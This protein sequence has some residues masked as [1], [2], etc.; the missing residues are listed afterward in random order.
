M[1]SKI[2]DA[3]GAVIQLGKP[4]GKGGEGVV[5]DVLGMPDF[6][7]KIYIRTPD[8]HTASKLSAMTSLANVHLLRVAAWPTTTLFNT[9]RAVTGFMMPKISGHQPVFQLYGPKLRLREFPTA[10]WRFLIHAAANAARAF[11]TIH[12]AGLVIGDVNHGNLLVSKDG[13]VRLIDCDSFQISKNGRLWLCEVGVG[14]HQPPEMQ[15]QIRYDRI[16]R[17]PNHDNFGLAVII[18]QLLCMARH[19]FAGVFRGPSNPPSI[20]EAIAQS[21]YAYSRDGQRTLMAP[22]PG[23]LKIDALTPKLRDLFELAF[24]PSA[25][26]GGRPSGQQWVGALEE[27]SAELRPCSRNKA[28]FFRRALANCPWCELENLS[29]VA[30]FPVVFVGAATSQAGFAVLWQEIC[31]VAEPPELPPL[32]D[33]G[34][35]K[36]NPSPSAIAA[37]RRARRARLLSYST[38]AASIAF[39]AAT[40]ESNVRAAIITSAAV[41]TI[42]ALRGR[43]SSSSSD[44][45]QT[46]L[47]NAKKDYDEIC[48]NW[49]LPSNGEFRG[50]RDKLDSIKQAFDALPNLRAQRLQRL[51]EQVR[52]RQLQEYLDRIAIA[53]TRLH[54]VGPNKI[55]SLSSHGIDTAGDIAEA[56]ILA[57]PGF[58]PATA[59]KLLSWRKLHEQRFQFD[60]KKGVPQSDIDT[61]ERDIHVERMKLERDA[62]AGLAKLKALVAF[63]AD[64]HRVLATQLGD[65]TKKYCEAAAD[66]K[67]IGVGNHAHKR[68]F[69][70]SSAAAFLALLSMAPQAS[71]WLYGPEAAHDARE[72]VDSRVIGGDVAAAGMIPRSAKPSIKEGPA[73]L[74]AQ[75]VGARQLDSPRSTAAADTAALDQAAPHAGS[76]SLP[77][78]PRT[79]AA[80]NRALDASRLSQVI[81]HDHGSLDTTLARVT[82]REDANVRDGPDSTAPVLG[83]AARGTSLRVYDRRNGWVHVGKDG[84]WG[85]IYS[86]LLQAEH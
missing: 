69:V 65:A 84:P 17:T 78:E 20:E 16:T 26:Q 29:G 21:R 37:S 63:A 36:A 66:A 64:R 45:V 49:T 41:A 40:T 62:A 46:R 52:A 32:P 38:L 7:A 70:I 44:I 27:L 43:N 61:V 19:P 31:K 55:A 5:Y 85:W 23:A 35:Q 9:S 2:L 50:T 15:G 83:V 82:T 60:P 58:G 68:L 12:S 74:A 25:R 6:A 4:L 54:G 67:I 73:L 34:K 1:L 56:R 14:T 76:N 24:A 3:S 71:T 22:P 53:A 30:L 75:A 28:H 33:L 8:A 39:V 42:L 72:R 51:Q 47:E 57:V 59:S 86:A 18:F 10:D 81:D 13:T 11:A 80:A 48:R 79:P 77:T